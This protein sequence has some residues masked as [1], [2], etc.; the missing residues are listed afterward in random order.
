MNPQTQFCHNSA[1]PARGRSGQGNIGVQSQREQR[2]RCKTCGRTFA[3]TKGKPRHNFRY[4]RGEFSRP[5]RASVTHWL[6]RDS[7]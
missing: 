6:C 5:Y 4:P 2:Y 7:Y 3:A 1:C